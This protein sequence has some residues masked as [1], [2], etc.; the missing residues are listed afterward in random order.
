M[1]IKS[2]L[3]CIIS[4]CVLA[5]VAVS[6]AEEKKAAIDPSLLPAAS[7]KKDVTYTTDIQP[8]FEKA[9]YRC[10]GPKSEK[11]KGG[12]RVDTLAAIIK[13]GKEGPDV[14]PGDSAKS[15]LVAAVAHVGDDDDFMPPPRNKANIP[16]LTKEQVGLVR[17]WIDQG[18][19]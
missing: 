2:L 17:A 14:I 18:A 10:H 7:D 3:S 6:A 1:S 11:P 12:L 13:G 5:A 8:I 4:G 9:C 19:K 16:P 15:P